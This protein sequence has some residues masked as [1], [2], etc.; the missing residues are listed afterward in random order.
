MG[1]IFVEKVIVEN[2]IK[3]VVFEKIKFMLIYFIV[4]IVGFFDSVEIF[5][6]LVLG[7][8]YVLKGYVDKIKFVIK[9]I[10]EIL[11]LLEDF[12][13]IKYF[14]KKMDFVVVFNFI[15][16]VMENVGLI[17]YCDSLLLLE[18]NLSV[19][20]CLWLLNVIVYEFVY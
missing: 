18:D 14:Y 8:I 5:G 2:G 17:I 10:L 7:K 9:Y 3:I 4:Y 16:G 19:I 6:L 13:G 11:V 1:N 15:Y 12:F 20:E